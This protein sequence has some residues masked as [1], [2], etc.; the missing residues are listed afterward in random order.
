MTGH[1][2]HQS[3]SHRDLHAA[4]APLDAANQSLAD[5][6]RASFSVLKFIMLVLVVLFLATGVKFIDTRDEAVVA[7]FGRLLPGTRPAGLSLAFP[8]PIDET[9]R[10][11]VHQDN[12]VMIDDHFIALEEHE[13]NLP[14]SQV[15]RQTLDPV[16][17]GALMTSDS[18]LVHVRWRLQYRIENLIDFVNKVADGGTE[19]TEAL[20]TAILDN[21]AIHVAAAEH[22]AE[23]I[24]RAEASDLADAVKRRVNERLEEL[25]TGITVAA[26]DIPESSVPIP[27]LRAFDAVS[28]AENQKQKRI[29]EA[30]QER[31]KI[32]NTCAGEAYP[33][34]LAA[35]D[36]WEAAKASG[37]GEAAA[38]HQA[39]LD[40]LIEFVAGGEARAEVFHAKSYYTEAVQGIQADE[41]EYN[42]LM[43]EYL[44]APDLLFARLWVQ[45]KRK[46]FAYEEVVK[47]YVP[48]GEKEIRIIIG[49]DPKQRMIDE[50][51]RIERR[52]KKSGR[53]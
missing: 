38:R 41:E 48:P 40:H 25:D 10:V 53:K 29:R 37:G 23:G 33:Q 43:D 15:G 1:H 14:L 24:T 12:V 5:A 42:A 39:K 50:M 31:D 30:E 52:E 22:T 45:T 17:D 18:G 6:L 26:L 20:I 28:S 47:N 16:R 35:L 49:A 32:L 2:H 4:D 21:A 13:K 46:I 19:D 11:P 8:Y 36:A 9:L 27:T 44:R 3:D 51:R 7:R 34:I